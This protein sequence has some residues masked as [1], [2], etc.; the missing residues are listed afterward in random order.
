MAFLQR[1]GGCYL[2]ISALLCFCVSDDRADHGLSGSSNTLNNDGGAPFQCRI[3]S[4]ENNDYV[5]DQLLLSLILS[6]IVTEYYELNK[7]TTA[8]I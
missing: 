1:Q 4:V 2:V 5:V 7:G 8:Q 3:A 6:L